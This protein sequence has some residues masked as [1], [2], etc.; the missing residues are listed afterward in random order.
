MLVKFNCRAVN[1]ILEL[2]SNYNIKKKFNFIAYA[3]KFIEFAGYFE[4]P[5]VELV[6]LVLWFLIIKESL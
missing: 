6:N 2:K 3:K 5:I 4:Q 1:Q